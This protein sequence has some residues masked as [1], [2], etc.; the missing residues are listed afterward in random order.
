MRLFSLNNPN[1]LICILERIQDL[2][3]QVRDMEMESKPK[4]DNSQNR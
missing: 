2:K 4:Q 3:Q 1:E